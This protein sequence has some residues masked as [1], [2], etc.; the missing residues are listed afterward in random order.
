[1]AQ[2]FQSDNC[3]I[4]YKKISIFFVFQYY[5][6]GL[7][8]L[9]ILTAILAQRFQ[10]TSTA[11]VCSLFFTWTGVCAHNYLHQRDN[12]RMVYFNL[13]F[14]SYRDWRISHVL[15]HHIFPNSML[16]VEVSIFEP[17]IVWIPRAKNLYQLYAPLLFSPLLYSV[18][19]LLEFGKK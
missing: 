15:S 19:Y 8:V 17:Y 14:M 5:I 16:D 2:S 7:F 10:S 1:M 9:T 6:D 18:F 4:F 11:I 12:F 3:E 13:I